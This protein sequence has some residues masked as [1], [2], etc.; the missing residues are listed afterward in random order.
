MECD[1]YIWRCPKGLQ[2]RVGN[3]IKK[4]WKRILESWKVLW[5]LFGILFAILYSI[6]QEN[7]GGIS[8]YQGQ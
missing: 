1:R 7:P 8:L 3:G 2:R 5:W 6:G 4:R